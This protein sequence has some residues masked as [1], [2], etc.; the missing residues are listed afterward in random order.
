[1]AH[2]LST[3]KVIALRPTKSECAGGPEHPEGS[4][5][6]LVIFCCAVFSLCFLCAVFEVDFVEDINVNVQDKTGRTPR[7]FAVQE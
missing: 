7:V 6:V 2:T 5:F 4:F 3:L 1:M